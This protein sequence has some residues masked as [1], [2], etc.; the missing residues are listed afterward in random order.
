MARKAGI[1]GAGI[2]CSVG[3]DPAESCARC[4][5]QS[6]VLDDCASMGRVC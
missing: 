2:K 3:D 4:L 6:M 1:V 5:C